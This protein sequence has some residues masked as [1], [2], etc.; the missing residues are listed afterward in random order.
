M[1]NIIVGIFF[2]IFLSSCFYIPLM[3]Y[4]RDAKYELG[5][6]NGK[7]EGLWQAAK[8]IEQTFGVYDGK[9]KYSRM[10]S[11]KTTDVI[12]VSDNGVKT[13]KVIP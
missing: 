12:V 7:I 11:V 9:S 13:I 8:S 1:K 4:E 5:R 2:G 10:F 3:M 6:A